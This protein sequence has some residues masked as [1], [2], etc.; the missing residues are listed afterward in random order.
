MHS[1]TTFDWDDLKY[2]LA[3][4]RHGSTLAAARSLGQSQSTVQRR[5]VRLEQR[6]GQQL[7]L[8]HPTGYRLTELGGEMRLHAER[9]EVAID[10]FQ[11]RLVAADSSMTGVI[12]VTCPEAFGTRLADSR[13]I[14]AFAKRHPDL[15]VELT[16]GGELLDLAKGEAD[17]AIRAAAPVEGALF[18]RKVGEVEWALY[19]DR[20]YVERH[21]GVSTLAEIGRHAV[22]QFDG[23]LTDHPAARWLQRTAPEARIVARSSN[24]ATLLM[25]VKSG[26]AIAPMP[27]T[28][29]GRDTNLIR[30]CGPIPSLVT[31]LYLLIHEDLKQTPRV[32]AF[33]DFLVE[34]ISVVRELTRAQNR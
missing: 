16:I 29:E 2:F 18:G 33:F 10:A 17:I 20:S 11:R 4:A 34:N 12:R 19:A 31:T 32:R 9:V 14:E 13:L 30:L 22:V 6:I 8:R 25:A 28:V 7:V 27:M 24:L 15:N 5:L 3:V 1:S 26:T 23:G 21:G